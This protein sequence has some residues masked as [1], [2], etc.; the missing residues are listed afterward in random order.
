MLGGRQLIVMSSFLNMLT[1]LLHGFEKV[2]PN[3]LP[4]ELIYH[5]RSLTANGKRNVSFDHEQ[6][7]QSPRTAESS[8]S[9]RPAK[10]TDYLGAIRWHH[11]LGWDGSAHF[12]RF[13]SRKSDRTMEMHN[14]IFKL[15]IMQRL[16]DR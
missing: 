10:T 6:P 14:N 13:D 12:A 3:V 15:Y 5:R 7:F 4:F 9:Y 2:I 8:A 16:F 11:M 1:L